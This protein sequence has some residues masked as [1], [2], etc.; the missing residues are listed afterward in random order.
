MMMP[1][2]GTGIGRLGDQSITDIITQAAQAQG[3]PVALALAQAQQESSLN[4][5]ATHKEVNGC[6]AYGLFQ[7]E[8]CFFAGQGDLTDP[9]INANVALGYL[10]QLYQKYGNW[11]SA[12]MAY[13]EGPANFDKGDQSSA[14]YAAG[15]LASAGMSVTGGTTTPPVTSA[16]APSTPAPSPPAAPLP[17]A[18]PGPPEIGTT[19]LATMALIAVGGILF[20]EALS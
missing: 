9:T 4:P 20:L 1:V 17:P 8:D 5:N 11:N 14:G 19:S 6:I 13:N 2:R 18:A 7:L 3:V 16:P 10:A 15:I 12:L